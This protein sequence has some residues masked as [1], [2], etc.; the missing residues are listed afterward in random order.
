MGAPHSPPL[1]VPPRL[2]W[3]PSG[4][5]SLARPLVRSLDE[6]HWHW[7]GTSSNSW[8]AGNKKGRRKRPFLMLMQGDWLLQRHN[9]LPHAELVAQ[10]ETRDPKFVLPIC[11]A[12]AWAAAGCQCVAMRLVTKI[13]IQRFCA[14]Q[15]A[16]I[17]DKL[18]AATEHPAR[19]EVIVLLA[20]C[21]G[22]DWRMCATCRHKPTRPLRRQGHVRGL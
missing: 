9:G 14:E 7:V 1:A 4:E 2:H 11:R 6:P 8:A 18:D 10:A 19:L 13:D 5:S 17:V 21:E 16:D 22:W 12:G 15:P 20:E 3:S